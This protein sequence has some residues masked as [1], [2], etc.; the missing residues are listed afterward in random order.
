MD[1]ACCAKEA[2]KWGVKYLHH[3]SIISFNK[4]IGFKVSVSIRYYKV[5]V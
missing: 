3:K 4:C 5:C 1:D 2:N